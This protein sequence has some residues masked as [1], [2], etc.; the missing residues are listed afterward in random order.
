MLSLSDNNEADLIEYI[1]PYGV[2]GHM[3]HL[4]VL[5]PDLCLLLCFVPRNW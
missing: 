1:F 2:L 3:W 5:I 4:V